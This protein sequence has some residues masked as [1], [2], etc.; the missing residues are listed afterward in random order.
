MK[1]NV[2]LGIK[3]LIHNT[4]NHFFDRNGIENDSEWIAR[5]L[6][7]EIIQ[8]IGHIFGKTRT[9]GYNSRIIIYWIIAFGNRYFCSE[10]H[11]LLFLKKELIVE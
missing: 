6:E 7:L 9:Q 8:F 11:L 1:K 2:F 4:I 3:K 10:L 5:I